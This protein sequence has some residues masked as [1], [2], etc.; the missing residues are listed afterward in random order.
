MKKCQ[1]YY[2]RILEQLQNILIKAEEPPEEPESLVDLHRQRKRANE[3]AVRFSRNQLYQM[4]RLIGEIKRLIVC[5]DSLSKNETVNLYKNILLA[6]QTGSQGLQNYINYMSL[7]QSSDVPEKIKELVLLIKELFSCCEHLSLPVIQN[8]DE[9]REFLKI[10][11]ELITAFDFKIESEEDNVPKKKVNKMEAK[12]NRES[13][14][15]SMY[16]AKLMNA[17]WKKQTEALAK[18]KFG[19]PSFFNKRR[20]KRKDD[21]KARMTCDI[22]TQKMHPKCGKY[23]GNK[24]VKFDPMKLADGEKTE[25]ENKKG[26]QKKTRC[27]TPREVTSQDE[28]IETIV[29]NILYDEETVS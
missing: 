15:Y 27:K 11:K 1:A 5:F 24:F 3:F 21:K 7:P 20:V 16:K 14:K 13:K 4:K 26:V 10:L 2:S 17:N 25:M 19:L 6:C 28:D 23:F 18:I 29:Q 12:E 8:D 22:Y 9:K